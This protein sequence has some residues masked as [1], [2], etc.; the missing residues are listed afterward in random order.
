MTDENTPTITAAQA[1][2]LYADG[3][4]EKGD[5]AG[6]WT[7][8]VNV[9]DAPHIRTSRWHEWYWLVLRDEKG[10]TYGI[11]YGRGL[12]ESQEPEF[13]WPWYGDRSVPGDR[14]LKLTR[15]YPHAVTKT[16]YR[17]TAPKAGV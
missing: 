16:V 6:G 12:T 10:D 15:L 5:T 4:G 1:A 9:E 8:A 7:L 2:E 14:E 3:E 17:T 11:D 13:P